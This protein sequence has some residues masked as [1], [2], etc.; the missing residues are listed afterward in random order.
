MSGISKHPLRP[1]NHLAATSGSLVRR[2]KAAVQG[3][4]RQKEIRK[5]C[6]FAKYYRVC[7][8]VDYIA[9]TI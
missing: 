9:L 1:A 3:V 2:C 8:L 4:S 7:L 5:K 6:I